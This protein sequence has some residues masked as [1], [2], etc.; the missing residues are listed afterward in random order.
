MANNPDKA[1]DVR[2]PFLGVSFDRRRKTERIWSLD[3]W[4]H[5]MG[6]LDIQALK[7]DVNDTRPM[8]SKD[9]PSSIFQVSGLDNRERGFNR[10][11]PLVRSGEGVRLQLRYEALRIV[12]GP[13]PT[14]EQA[15]QELV[16]ELQGKGYTQLRLQRLF[17]EG[18]YLGTQEPW[19][20]YPDPAEPQPSIREGRWRRWW[21]N[22][23]SREE[24]PNRE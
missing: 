15:L 17:E 5:S 21:R 13:V 12:I 22:L 1:G 20:E 24:S 23:W 7:D 19:V 10:Q 2:T 6:I 4:Q 11:A 3:E 18:Q 8:N 9:A 14:E 16:R